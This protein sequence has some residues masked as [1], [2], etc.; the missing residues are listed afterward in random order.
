MH[1]LTAV[2]GL[3]PGDD[4]HIASFDSTVV[5][6]QYSHIDKS[7]YIGT[8]FDSS[9]NSYDG[10]CTFT[11]MCPSKIEGVSGLALDFD[12]FDDFIN[13]GNSGADFSGL[14]AITV[15]AWIKWSGD[16]GNLDQMVWRYGQYRHT[17][18]H[19]S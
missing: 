9:N 3:P 4:I 2:S 16:M 11:E 15:A 19:G 7:V 12:G 1:I 10:L 5:D 18:L 14:D 6:L 8:H 13:I 17:I